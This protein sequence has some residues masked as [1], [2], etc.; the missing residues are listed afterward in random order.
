MI[1]TLDPSADILKPPLPWTYLQI[2]DDEGNF[3]HIPYKLI[4]C[5]QK[6]IDQKTGR[7][8]ILYNGIDD[9]RLYEISGEKR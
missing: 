1:I 8:A 4:I 7:K 2:K 9:I 6:I 3:I 5:M